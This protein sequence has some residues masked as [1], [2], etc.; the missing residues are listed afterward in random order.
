[1]FLFVSDNF[2]RS[3]TADAENVHRLLEDKHTPFPVCSLCLQSVSVSV[4]VKSLFNVVFQFSG[5]RGLFK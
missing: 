3:F 4:P 5:L 2:Q 1:M